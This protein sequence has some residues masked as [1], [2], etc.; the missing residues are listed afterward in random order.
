MQVDG[1]DGTTE[2][3][4][5][6]ELHCC[7]RRHVCCRTDLDAA[8]Q[9]HPVCKEK[10]Q[11]VAKKIATQRAVLIYLKVTLAAARTS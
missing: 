6:R 9:D 5:R 3:D 10:V 8:M 7:Q 2:R 11:I 4:E 1:M